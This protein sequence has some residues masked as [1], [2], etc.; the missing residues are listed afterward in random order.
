M[1]TDGRDC[2]ALPTFPGDPSGA[3]HPGPHK[4]TRQPRWEGEATSDGFAATGY[5]RCGLQVADR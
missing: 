2:A 5:F 4:I 1:L 3:D